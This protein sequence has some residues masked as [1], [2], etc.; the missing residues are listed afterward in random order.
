MSAD[1]AGLAALIGRA[2]PDG[3]KPPVERWNPPFCG[4]IDMAIDRDG[5]WHYLGSPIGREALVR[6]FA[7]VL[8]RED[9][10]YFLVTPVEKVGIR[11]AD[12][13]FLAVEMHVAG[14]GPER[15]ITLRTNVGDVVEVGP[16][17]R[18]RFA[19]EEGS[20]GLMPYAHVRAGLEARFTR[21]LS[22]DAAELL[23]EGPGGLLGIHG[24]GVFHALPAEALGGA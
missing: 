8:K 21:A 16:E 18:L 24:G 2:A 17:H 15:R 4:D 19:I 3:R 22:V 11:V 13:P 23:E 10:S 12:V 5:R 6:L 20:G 14:T 1:V 9:D 7:G